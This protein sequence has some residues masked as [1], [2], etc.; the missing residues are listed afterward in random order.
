MKRH[1]QESSSE[2]SP[3]SQDLIPF[4]E[5]FIGDKIAEGSHTDVHEASEN[6]RDYVVK[7]G[8]AFEYAPPFLKA[9]RIKFPR[10]TINNLLAK[11]LGPKFKIMPTQEFI[12]NGMAEYM[13]I[14]EYFGNEAENAATR[15]DL[16]KSL[17][18]REDP[19]Y[20]DL[21]NNL[22]PEQIKMLAEILKLHE[23]E[24]F[25]PGEDLVI[26][27]PPETT[28]EQFKKN[29]EQEKNSP[30]TY[31]IIQDRVKGDSVKPLYEVAEDELINSPEL[32]ERL[33]IF[34]LLAKKMYMDTG[35]LVDSRPEEVAKHPL[36]WFQQTSNILVDVKT[37]TVRF[38]DTRWL[39]DADSAVGKKGVNLIEML[40][41]KSLNRSLKKY[42]EILEVW[43]DIQIPRA[44]E[45]VSLAKKETFK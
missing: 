4:K 17:S 29:K 9:L 36:E 38:V 18:D 15:E 45:T 26:G 1:F 22:T 12:T 37:G 27:H 43:D 7:I 24:N 23:N 32:V 5:G 44:G 2:H 40:G 20:K 13:L 10:Q 8:Q 30:L 21:C 39:W 14:K 34:A 11:V 28:M 6:G 41:I 35:K 25:L 19:F 3:N 42:A 31:Y 16:V 33:A